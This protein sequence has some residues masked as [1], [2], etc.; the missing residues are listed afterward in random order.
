MLGVLSDCFIEQRIC[1]FFGF[2]QDLL[3]LFVGIGQHLSALL[4]CAQQCVLEG[5]LVRTV[6]AH[7]V[8][9]NLDF[10]VGILA[11]VFHFTQV[12]LQLLHEFV[13]VLRLVAKRYLIKLLVSDILCTIT[14]R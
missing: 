1:L 12:S 13:H 4:L 7:L 6:L 2:T 5:I 3:R 14:E 10:A 8:R 11:A 9:K